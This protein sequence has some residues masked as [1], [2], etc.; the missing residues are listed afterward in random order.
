M[1]YRTQLITIRY[2]QDIILTSPAKNGWSEAHSGH[3][4]QI[5]PGSGQYVFINIWAEP[6]GQAWS[7]QAAYD[8]VLRLRAR[9]GID[10]DP[11]LVPSQRGH[12]LAARRRPDRGRV[13][14]ARALIGS[15]HV[16]GLRPSDGRGRAGGAGEGRLA[17]R[18]GSVVVT[19]GWIT[20][21][22]R[23]RWQQRAAAELA[24]I[25]A[26]H[27]GFPVLAWTVTASGGALSGQV[28]G[29]G[30]CAAFAAWRQALA[31]GDVL[32]TSVAAGTWV[33]ARV[34]RGGVRVTVTATIPASDRNG[35][36]L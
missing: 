29:A 6:K 31:L 11:A 17:Y 3:K 18:E 4:V 7:Y 1:T 25:L 2:S 10:F 30:A 36:I 22:D 16:L 27:P 33:R 20:Q 24:A 26:A 28:T 14:A 15:S 34:W 8:L 32:E 19:G 21:A 13:H 23:S 35:V 12:A 9:T 5:M